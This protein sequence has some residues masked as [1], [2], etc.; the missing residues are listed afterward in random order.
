MTL[1]DAGP[2]VALIDTKDPHHGACVQTAASLPP[3]PMMTTWP[4]LTE[5]M[6]LVY[7]TGGVSAQ[8][9][10]WSLVLNGN[11]RIYQAHAD[12]CRRIYDLMNQYADMPLDMADA[13]LA[14]AA[15]SLGDRC[16][17]SIDS[18]LR[19][20]RLKNNHVFDLLP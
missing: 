19:S 14:S 18:R 13:S 10:L 15:E 20:V 7:R 16:L 4:C 6:H 11:L 5:A 2:L 12:E 8:N 9:E 17:F 1:C 3:S